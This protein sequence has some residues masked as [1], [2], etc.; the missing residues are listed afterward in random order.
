M[1]NVCQ[2]VHYSSNECFET[3]QWK[4]IRYI[5]AWIQQ[6]DKI[7]YIY[8]VICCIYLM[9]II[10][11]LPYVLLNCGNFLILYIRNAHYIFAVVSIICGN[12]IIYL[13]FAVISKF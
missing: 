4:V 12:L 11:E 1:F 9:F 8:T 6:Y 7:V 2:N 13:I 3:L 10:N 5:R